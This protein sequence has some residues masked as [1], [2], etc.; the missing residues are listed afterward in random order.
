M[1]RE[2]R[3]E[4]L[5]HEL[6]RAPVAR[7]VARIRATGPGPTRTCDYWRIWRTHAGARQASTACSSPTCSASTT[8][9]RAISTRALRQCGADPGQ[10]SAAARSRPM[11][12]RDRASRLR[13]HR[14]DS[15]SSIPT[16]S[17]GASRPLDHL[18][19]GPRRLEHRH[20]LPGER[21][22]QH[23]PGRHRRS[24][25]TATS[26]P[27]NI[28]EVCY[29]LWEGSWEDG[30]VL[31]DRERR[32]L[33]RSGQGPPR[34]AIQGQ[35]LHGSRHSPQRAL[36]AAHAGALP[37]RRVQ[38]RQGTSPAQHAECMFV[39]A[40]SQGGAEEA[41]SR[42]I[43]E[44]CRAARARSARDPR[45]QPA[46]R[47]RRRDRRRSAGEVR[48]VSRY[49][50]IDGAL[51]LMSGWTGIDFGQYRAR[52]AA[53]PSRQTNAVQSAVED[54]HDAPIP[55]KVW[56]VREMADWVRHRRLWPGVRRLARRRLP[57]CCR[58]GSRRP[59]WTASTSL[60]R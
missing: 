15:R 50:A 16:P 6:R 57:T 28:C 21:R 18:T 48:G 59:M 51:A 60:M 49:A 44:A 30:A 29:K 54:I 37:G 26:S 24:T 9:T 42:N 45:L 23:R 12:L 46:D 22:T 17:P 5:R 35:L 56:T 58:N 7:P 8:S 38:P 32:H 53:A 1:T 52:R 25:T 27:T 4:R 14:V 19:E 43:R 39:A 3:L 33:H 2:I 36:A 47:D 20:L 41:M 40:P 55:I 31:R 13:P 11:A 10:R 34:S